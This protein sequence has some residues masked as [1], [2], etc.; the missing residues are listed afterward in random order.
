[1]NHYNI[2]DEPGPC[3]KGYI[4]IGP[5]PYKKGSCIKKTKICKKKSKCEKKNNGLNIHKLNRD[6]F[7]K[8][9]KSATKRFNTGSLNLCP[10][11]Y[12]SA[13]HKFDV[14]PS[15]YANGYA[16]GVCKGKKPNFF[17]EIKE[18]LEYTKRLNGK[19]KNKNNLQ[20]WYE[21]K[22]VNVCKKGS[23][24]GGY[25]NCGSGKG[26]YDSKNY[27]YCRPYYKLE[28][29]TLV[30]APELSKKQIKKMC[31]KKQSMKQGI[32][33]KP[34]KIYLKNT[35]NH[36]NIKI[37]SKNKRGEYIFEDY[38]DFRPNLS[39]RDIFILGSFGGTYWRPIKSAVTNKKYKNEYL[40][41]PEEWWEGI[42]KRKLTKSW[43]KYDKKINKYGVKVGQTLEEWEDKDWITKYH[44]YCWV[45]WYSDFYG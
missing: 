41:Y 14:Y 30:T 19:K 2:C 34:T 18:D 35:V 37:P 5:E 38:P 28:G 12:C 9:V 39:P 25:A 8:C 23:G 10:N 16:S 40:D 15:A 6:D 29:T 1:M 36:N 31:K 11:G 27:P 32:M 21:E 7:Y 26:I 45:Q 13:K 43:G 20:R 17:G 3:K 22:W 4:Y 44:P 42:P 33:G 24:P